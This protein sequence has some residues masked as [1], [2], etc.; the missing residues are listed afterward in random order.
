[1]HDQA[2]AREAA[3]RRAGYGHAEVIGPGNARHA[4]QLL[5]ERVAPGA[6]DQKGHGI[7]KLFRF[8]FLRPDYFLPPRTLSA[9]FK[10]ASRPAVSLGIFSS[11]ALAW[12]RRYP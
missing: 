2:A 8:I 10:R 1:D 3:Q 5:Q 11:T 4:I 7:K 6:F 9:A 12:S